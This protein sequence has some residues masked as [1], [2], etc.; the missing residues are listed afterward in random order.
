MVKRSFA[1]PTQARGMAEKVMLYMK[2]ST[3][4]LG[5]DQRK[6]Q[7]PESA[8]VLNASH[9]T[10]SWQMGTFFIKKKKNKTQSHDNT[11]LTLLVFFLGFFHPLLA[12]APHNQMNQYRM[13]L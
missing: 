6:D 8:Y 10:V 5:L 4:V 12:Q 9:G 3:P 13:A 11:F 2:H 7:L 1:M